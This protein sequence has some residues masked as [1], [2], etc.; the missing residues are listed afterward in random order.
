MLEEL[1]RSP[2][3]EVFFHDYHLYL[4]PAARARGAAGCA[5]AHFIHIPWAQADCWRVLPGRCA[6]AVHEGLLA[7]DVVG[8]HT[9]RW[10]RSNFVEACSA[11]R[12]AEWDAERRLPRH[13]ASRSPS[14]RDEFERAPRGAPAVLEEERRSRTRPELLIVRVDRTDPSKNIVRGFSRLRAAAP[15]YP[16]LAGGSG[17]SRCS[18]RR[19]RTSRRTPSTWSR[20]SARRARSTSASAPTA[21]SRSTCGRRQLPA[22]VA[23]YKQFD[24][25]LVNPIFDGMNLVAKEAPFVN[26]RDGVVVLSENAGAHEDIGEWTITI[27][28]FDI[29]GRPRRCTRRST[30]PLEE[31]A[32]AAEAIRRSTRE[33]RRDV[34]ERPARRP[35]PAVRCEPPTSIPA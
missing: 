31:R 21:G 19:G 25:L 23:A 35:R 15:A 27:N 28:P 33:R 29:E 17:C 14:T 9:D 16:E 8:F 30:M 24:V 12:G 32:R 6:R 3:A 11:S 7:N 13:R 18:T 22:A 1:D 2:D 10:R 20:S 5:L 34:G 4:A 26:E